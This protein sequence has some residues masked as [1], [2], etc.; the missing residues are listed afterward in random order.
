MQT[1]WP[2]RRLDLVRSVFPFLLFA[3]ICFPRIAFAADKVITDAD[4]GGT[5]HLKAGEIVEL[6]LKANPTTGFMWYIE[7]DS[8]PLLKLV[9]QTQTQIEATEPDMVGRPVFQVFKFQ[10]KQHYGEGVLHM[11]YVRSWDPPTPDDE[12][13]E[14]H[15]VVE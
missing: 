14:L 8:T 5:I 12:R 10:A 9:H 4:K 3:V 7:K 15:V 11:H 13:F 2:L 1:P 6:R